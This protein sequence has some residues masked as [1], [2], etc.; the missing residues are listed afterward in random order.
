MLARLIDIH[1]C[2]H[3]CFEILGRSL[4]KILQLTRA[5]VKR[6]T[7]FTP[8]ETNAK[9]QSAH[10]CN[11]FLN[12]LCS[13]VSGSRIAETARL[14]LLRWPIAIRLSSHWSSITVRVFTSQAS[15][16]LRG[17]FCL[18]SFN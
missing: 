7:A 18:S 8:S 17:S 6:V 15:A 10:V 2:R 12:R 9:G 5:A 3:M 1:V 14:M 13:R 11:S 16:C 4:Y